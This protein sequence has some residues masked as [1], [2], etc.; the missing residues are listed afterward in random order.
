MNWRK[1]N[2]RRWALL[3]VAALTTFALLSACALD[4]PETIIEPR[5]AEISGSDADVVA[6]APAA[7]ERETVDATAALTETLDQLVSAS[8]MANADFQNV[9]GEVTGSIQELALDVVNGNVLYAT[10]EYG[11]FL[12]IGDTELPMP[13]SAF[14]LVDMDHYILNFEEAQT[15][16]LP[17]TTTEWIDPNTGGL[18]ADVIDFWE[19]AAL[20]PGIDISGTGA[21]V[22]VA[23]F[24][25]YGISDIGLGVGNLV[26][27]LVDLENGRVVY[28]LISYE[29]GILDNDFI[30][31]PFDALTVTENQVY[32]ADDINAQVIEQAPLYTSNIYETPNLETY[33]AINEYWQ[34]FGYGQEQ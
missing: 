22:S 23:D 27:L 3:V 12:D 30:A 16:T 28:L 21:V 18:R 14:T 33:V 6:T 2:V 20:D 29:P 15:V 17:D 9:D 31:V 4:E 25:N 7:E 10:V 13:L 34:T 11:G 1:S 26:D 8:S 24:L 19:S 32:F 5:P